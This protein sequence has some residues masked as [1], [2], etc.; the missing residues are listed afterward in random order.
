MVWFFYVFI[1]IESSGGQVGDRFFVYRYG[2]GFGVVIYYIVK[3]VKRNNSYI[4]VLKISLIIGMFFMIKY[5]KLYCQ[6]FGL[7]CK[8]E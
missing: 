7:K 6:N 4:Y 2:R 1:L 5:I 3:C 8:I